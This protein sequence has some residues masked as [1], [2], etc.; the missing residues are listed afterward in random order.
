MGICYAYLSSSR[1]ELFKYGML[2]VRRQDWDSTFG[3]FLRSLTVC[4][5]VFQDG[6]LRGN[7]DALYCVHGLRQ[8]GCSCVTHVGNGV[9]SL[10]TLRITES[11][12][13]ATTTISNA[14]DA[15]SL[16]KCTTFTG[17][18]AIATD[19]AE[20]VEIN[21]LEEIQGSLIAA[22]NSV[23]TTIGSN[24]LE[25][26]SDQI[27]LANLSNLV[28]LTFPSWYSVGTLFVQNVTS[29][30]VVNL[31][32]SVQQIDNLYILDTQLEDLQ[33]FNVSSPQVQ[34]LQI[35]GN[36][37]LVDAYFNVGNITTS[38]MIANNSGSTTVRLP[39]LTYAYELSIANASSV[40]LTM[41]QS[42]SQNLDI[43]YSQTQNFSCPGLTFVGGDLTMGNNGELAGLNLN[44][45]VDV[46]GTLAIED[47]PVLMDLSGLSS[48]SNIGSALEIRGA[49]TKYVS[50]HTSICPTLR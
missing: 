20:V 26:V 24:S 18:V 13:N 49:F 36:Y 28:N 30:N 14:A 2:P 35:T 1:P 43:S 45:L 47:N 25:T 32:T 16:A 48:L 11:C 21:G 33:G 34:T 5:R 41:L 4:L 12:N 29:P 46:Q 6:S 37:Y 19:S 15:S 40:D 7:E 50:A 17:V 39:S 38:A 22:N 27:T 31:E 3:S 10:L 42:V 44:E 23:L 9:I 8:C